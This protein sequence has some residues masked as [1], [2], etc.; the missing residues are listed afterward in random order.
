MSIGISAMHALRCVIVALLLLAAWPAAAADL[1][2]PRREFVEARGSRLYVQIAGSGRPVVFL[3]GGL[4]HFDNTFARQRDELALSHTVIGIDQRGHGHSP[5]DARPF[6]YQDMAEDTAEVIRR[7]GFGAVDVVGHS[8]GANVALRLARAHPERVRRVVVSGAN[9]RAGLPADAL[10]ERQ[11]WSDAQ[12]AEFLTT[13]EQRLPP[14]FRTD[15]QAVTPDGP[16]HWSVVL[17]K[18]YR[19]WLTPVVMDAADLAAIQAPVLVIAGDRDFASLEETVEIFR[20][21]RS[22]QL[23]IVPGSGHG[24]FSARPELVNLALRRFLDAP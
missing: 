8:D 5:D 15:Y 6:S 19:L 16:A 13:F 2:T 4:H 1:P 23:F 12:L 10:R 3:H 20:G 21:L 14:S 24:T 22:S 9:L 17:A 11:N 7:L 18:S